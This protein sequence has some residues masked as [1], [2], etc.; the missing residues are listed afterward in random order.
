M[1]ELINLIIKEKKSLIDKENQLCMLLVCSQT[2]GNCCVLSGIDK[3]W[4]QSNN[5][6]MGEAR[7]K[8]CT[9]SSSPSMGPIPRNFL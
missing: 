5:K 2:V 8:D 9:I 1:L 6:T 4:H 7:E 3:Q